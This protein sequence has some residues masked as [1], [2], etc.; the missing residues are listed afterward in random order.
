MELLVVISIIA[1]LMAILMP[2]LQ[3][4]REAARTVTCKAK[5]RQIGLAFTLYSEYNGDWI[6]PSVSP[7]KKGPAVDRYW[8][9]RFVPYVSTDM[10]KKGK[11]FN[12]PTDKKPRVV[13]SGS[14]TYVLSYTYPD[15]FGDAGR[16]GWNIPGSPWALIKRTKFSRP[17]DIVALL[18]ANHHD[19]NPWSY[20][21]WDLMTFQVG[22][23]S[24]RIGWYC[25]PS[26]PPH[27]LGEIP[28]SWAS[29]RH[30]NKSNAVLVDG[31]AETFNPNSDIAHSYWD[32][33]SKRMI[34]DRP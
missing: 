2:S 13:T 32:R 17:S 11:L 19:D 5:I 15:Y 16:K 23:W 22:A 31:H 3:R 7:W 1:L 26:Y 34:V 25:R 10:A 24:G 27:Y 4:A 30:A 29:W 14:E 8:Y 9:A 20:K 28:R 21:H 6:C 33:F 18:C 12:C